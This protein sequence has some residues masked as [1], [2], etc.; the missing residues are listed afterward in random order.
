[1]KK[2]Y[3]IEALY[4]SRM[5]TQAWVMFSPETYD[6]KGEASRAMTAMRKTA[7]HQ[8]RVAEA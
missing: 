3:R 2:Q 1:M 7:K 4:Q 8:L 5:G 6:T